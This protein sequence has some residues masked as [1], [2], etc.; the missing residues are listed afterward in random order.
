MDP[1]KTSDDLN[2]DLEA[3]DVQV[4]S[5]TVAGGSSNKVDLPKKTIKKQLLTQAMKKKRLQW[6]KRYKN[7]TSDD[8]SKVLF[9]DESHFFVQGHN[10]QFVRRSLDEP[11]RQEHF[12]QSVKHPDKKMFSGCFSVE[13]AGALVPI[14]GMMNSKMYLPILDRRVKQELEKI[15]ENSV[16]QQDSARCHKAKIVTR[17]FEEN[18]I[19][20]LEWPGNSPDLTPIENLW[21]IVKKD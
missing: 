2:M 7:W 10:P 12:F 11:M 21:A 18:Q 4:S 3:A 8:W 14:D 9:S 17:F 13:G 19:E 6:A 15:G 16:F 5:S 1:R 20:L